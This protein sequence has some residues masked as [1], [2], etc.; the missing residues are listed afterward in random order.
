MS[1]PVEGENTK[2]RGRN[3]R[4]DSKQIKEQQRALCWPTIRSFNTDQLVGF[5]RP[6]GRPINAKIEEENNKRKNYMEMEQ[7]YSGSPSENEAEKSIRRELGLPVTKQLI[8]YLDKSDPNSFVDV[9]NFKIIES[10]EITA[11]WYMLDVTIKTGD[12]I[13]IHSSHFSEMQKPSFVADMA[14][15]SNQI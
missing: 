2:R 11:K 3:S 14:A 7:V 13:R 8:Y 1:Q 12:I 10:F 15:Q 4:K 9:E 5:Y 6:Y